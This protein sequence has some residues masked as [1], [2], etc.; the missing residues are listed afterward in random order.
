M[1]AIITASTGSPD[2]EPM[3]GRSSGALSSGA[4]ECTRPARAMSMSPSPI[5][6]RPRFFARPAVAHRNA[7]TPASTRGGP[8][9]DMLTD[10]SW[11]NRA[12]PTF[13]PA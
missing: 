1:A 5:P 7:S 9:S 10:N 3:T 6:M 2:S 13:A 8:T 11:V 4:S 12:V